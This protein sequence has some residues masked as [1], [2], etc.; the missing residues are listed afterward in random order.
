MAGEYSLSNVDSPRRWSTSFTYEM[1]FG[2]GKKWLDSNR[3]LN[4]VVGGWSVNA[5]GIYQTG[6]PLQITQSSNNNSV[7]GFASQRPNATGVSPVTSGSL[8]D[9]LASYIN[10]AAFSQARAPRS[11][12]F[13]ERSICADRAR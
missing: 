13:R 6:F 1:P 5:V 3:A 12:M 10:P 4:Y 2:K 8:E 7:F 11:A 9:R